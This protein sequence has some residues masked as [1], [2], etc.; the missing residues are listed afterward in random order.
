MKVPDA[1]LSLQPP[2]HF[3]HKTLGVD[4][5]QIDFGSEPPMVGRLWGFGACGE[6]G[7]SG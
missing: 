4:R 3:C 2:L 6:T 1:S 7:L 5:G